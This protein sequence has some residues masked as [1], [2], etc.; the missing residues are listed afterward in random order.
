MNKA[1]LNRKIQILEEQKKVL[2]KS[3]YDLLHTE[4]V[5]CAK[6]RKNK[7][8]NIMKAFRELQQILNILETKYY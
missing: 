5:E 4:C 1:D 7:H 3:N 2:L 8:D 6:I